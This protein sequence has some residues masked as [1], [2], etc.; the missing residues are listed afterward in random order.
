MPSPKEAEGHILVVDDDHQL[1]FDLL[2]TGPIRIG[3]RAPLHLH[4][5]LGG[6]FLLFL[7]Y[8]G[9]RRL[10]QQK[11]TGDRDCV[12]ERDANNLAGSMMAA[13]IRSTYFF[14]SASKP[15][16]PLPPIIRPT[17][18]PPST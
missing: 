6:S 8:S 4:F 7:R 2:S 18:T 13:S 11:H 10:S 15:S 3:D 1:H 9:H 17:T 5:R 14:R 12:F 16:F